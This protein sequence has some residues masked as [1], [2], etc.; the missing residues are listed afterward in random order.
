MGRRD[1]E[2]PIVPRVNIGTLGH[3][4]KPKEAIEAAITGYLDKIKKDKNYTKNKDE[5]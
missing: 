5:R 1:N 3:K 4:D 2:K